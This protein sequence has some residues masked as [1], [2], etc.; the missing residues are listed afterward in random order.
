MIEQDERGVEFERLYSEAFSEMSDKGFHAAA[1]Y[2]PDL[3]CKLATDLQFDQPDA[4]IKHFDVV[5]KATQNTTIHTLA[6]N[7]IGRIL[8]NRGQN[9]GAVEHFTRAHA[10]SPQHNWKPPSF[11]CC[12]AT[13]RGGSLSMRPG[14]DMPG[15]S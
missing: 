9:D 14:G 15:A 2:A 10:L 8:A 5:L 11:T 1:A 3:W 6:I 12:R 4:A 13:M 7:E